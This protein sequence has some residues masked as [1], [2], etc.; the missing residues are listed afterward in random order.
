MS[1]PRPSGSEC[2]SQCSDD[3][4]PM[5]EAPLP[6]H[7]TLPIALVPLTKSSPE[8]RITQKEII[9]GEER[10]KFLTIKQVQDSGA[11]DG[12]DGKGEGGDNGATVSQ[13]PQRY[14]VETITMTTVT[15]RRIVQREQK[16]A[17]GRP[18]GSVGA[19]AEVSTVATTP[20]TVTPA[21]STTLSPIVP[22]GN[23]GGSTA[24]PAGGGG[25]TASLATSAAS[26]DYRLL[27]QQQQQQQQQKGLRTGQT[28]AG[29]E[30][31]ASQQQQ[32]QAPSGG[33]GSQGAKLLS[34]KGFM[35]GRG[36]KRSQV[37]HHSPLREPPPELANDDSTAVTS[38][39]ETSSKR[40]V[41]FNEEST[42][43]EACCD[44]E[45]QSGLGEGEMGSC[46][47]INYMSD[48]L[49]RHSSG[50]F[51]NALRP[52]SAVRQL[53]P[54]SAIQPLLTTAISGTG[55]T[56]PSTTVATVTSAC[57][58]AATVTASSTGSGAG[59]CPAA[60]S[61]AHSTVLTQEALKA[62]D[63]AK[64]AAGGLVHQHS[65]TSNSGSMSNIPNSAA[66]ALALSGAAGTAVTGGPG[67]TDTIRRSI[68]RNALR[69]SLIKYEPKKKIPVKDVTSLEER[70]RQLTCDI[71]DP[72]DE[73]GGGEGS[74]QA[75]D[76]DLS[77]MERRDSP[78]G[79]ENPQ[80]PKYLP[81][82]S[83]S[84]SSSASSSS[85][86]SNGST[87]KKIT[88][89][90]HRDRRQEKIPEADENPIVII[91]QD[92]R[93]PAGPDIGMGV[94]I[95]GA[96]TQIHQPPQQ[97][98]VDSRRQFLSTLAPLTAC[99]AGQR[100]D[101]SYYT[102]AHPGDRSSM[103][104]SQSTEYSIGDIDAALHDDDGKKVAPDV[105]AGTPGQESDELAAFVQQEGARTERLKKR[106]SAETSTS[107]PAS[108]AG[109][110]D[111]EQNDYG[112][113][114]RPSV[115]GIK[116]RFGST[117]EILQ[118]MQ[119][120]LAA[121][122]PPQ[123]KSQSTTVPAQTQPIQ[124][125]TLPRPSMHVAAAKQQ[126]TTHQHTA[127]WSY[128]P[129]VDPATQS[130]GVAHQPQP[131]AGTVQQTAAGTAGVPSAGQ[132]TNMVAAVDPHGN[133]YHI[134]V[135][136]R[137][138]YHGQEAIYQNCANLPLGVQAS[139]VQVQSH[140]IHT[141]HQAVHTAHHI[142]QMT[143]TATYG[144]F[145]RSPTRRP[146]S[147]PP[148]RNYHQT[149]VLIP[150]NAETY[151]RYTAQEQENYRRQ[152]NIVEYQQVTQQTIRV[153]VGYPLPGMQLHVV[154]AGARAGL[155][156]HYSTL[157]RLGTNTAPVNA[158]TGT[159]PPAQTGAAPPP[160]QGKPPAYSQYPSDGKPGVVKFT[161]RGAPE[162]AASVQPSDANQL[163]SPTGQGHGPP[164]M[165]TSMASAS[166]AT[167]TAGTTAGAVQSGVGGG[168]QGGVGT[169][170][171]QTNAVQQQQ[172]S[173]QGA[174]F[175]AMNIKLTIR[176]ERETELR[177]GSAG[178]VCEVQEAIGDGDNEYAAQPLA[179]GYHS[180]GAAL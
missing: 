45:V 36:E 109:S 65:L 134:P 175:Y 145:A 55:A 171:G 174:V 63:D 141:Q 21:L 120:Q 150:Y 14:I 108:G 127:S 138:S 94:Q 34:A 139:A 72:I 98:H 67:E 148:L 99:V 16:D 118:Q 33:T 119:A 20:A 11:Q 132:P 71:D 146:E 59:M 97:R 149:M 24:V 91:P 160:P 123:T 69:R 9:A 35:G 163:L 19:G 122:T 50:L 170:S 180:T 39:E 48:T 152:H 106:Y 116:P 17:P 169:T 167:T 131:P 95:Q 79:E 32:Q 77:E 53:F 156:P 54:S 178:T 60:L 49:K 52:N 23:E 124:S 114:S 43:R 1:Q 75:G 29:G 136:T 5:L 130:K 153:P 47:A 78:A 41:R 2:D 107:A 82:K 142:H 80:Q 129:A 40:S 104:S 96:H 8:R 161:E 64:K 154:A 44:G 51:H 162:G 166:S 157:P 88:D 168:S 151:H 86:G 37:E 143:D 6:P 121:P 101:L 125:N 158:S 173:Q 117:N 126:I 85:S 102:L 144:K 84:P 128:Y 12:G 30:G 140:Q 164:G 90:F 111:D 113:N 18:T 137:H 3:I 100:D 110:D 46:R 58:N 4:S 70:I 89:L 13:T 81:D 76:G 103:A 31:S 177:S 25:A 74:D 115:R 93:C 26:H 62:F 159:G 172:Q 10:P 22:A 42:I 179:I 38:D 15:E 147:P 87:Y 56:T 61:A 66:A 105:I 155:P 27:Q 176:L 112:F 28:M 57:P 73:T 165:A 83:F 68:E 92:C 7:A 135:Q 133:Y